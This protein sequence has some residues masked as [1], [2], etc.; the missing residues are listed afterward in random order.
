VT[1]IA[2]ERGW[3]VGDRDRVARALAHGGCVAPA[4]EA[5]ALFEASAGG[6][7]TV[8]ELVARRLRGEP[9]A[10]ITGWVSFCGLR[11]HVEPG[12]FVPRP[13][14][15]ALARRAAEVLPETGRAVDLCTGTGA[16]AAVMQAARPRAEV[17]A[18]DIDGNAIV[19][20][21]GNGVRA[22]RGDLDGPLPGSFRGTVDLVTAVVPYVP[23]E[24][25]H[26][27][28]RDVLAHEPRRSLDG[29]PGGTAVLVRAADA[30]ARLLAPGGRVL[31]EIGGVQADAV[32]PAFAALG[33]ATIRVHRDA[34]G[35]DR[36]IEGRRP[37]R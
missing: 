1:S 16:V 34:D 5:A 21:R 9:L 4:A 10:W 24:E 33:L 27:L 19:C 7:G 26:L 12:V 13:H 3:T 22:I 23:Q 30:A 32:A 6:L 37:K 14:T 2:H 35:R 15:E 11:I 28:P 18:T 17:V 29:G 25:L 31:L 36:A 8:D 20:A